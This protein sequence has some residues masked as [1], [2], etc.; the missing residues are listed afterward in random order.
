VEE[1]RVAR[2]FFRGESTACDVPALQ[3]EHLQSRPAQVSL[4]Y[5][6][7]VTRS[8]DDA[9]VYHPRSRSQ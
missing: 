3:T 1:A 4:E 8:Q 2:V 6:T 5:Q 9:V 7:V